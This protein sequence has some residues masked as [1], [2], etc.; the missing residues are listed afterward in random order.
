LTPMARHRLRMP[1]AADGP[2]IA[3]A[4]QVVLERPG[5]AS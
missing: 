2:T 3:A 5:R 1:A 4:A